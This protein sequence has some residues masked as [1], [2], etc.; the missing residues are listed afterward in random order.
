[1]FKSD[2]G[3][4]FVGDGLA[5]PRMA[6]AE[7]PSPELIPDTEKWVKASIFFFISSSPLWKHAPFYP[8]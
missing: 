4:D 8:N 6:H 5:G 7:F 3:V 2:D 1:M